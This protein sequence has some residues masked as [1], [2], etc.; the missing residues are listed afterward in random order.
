MDSFES[1]LNVIHKILKNDETYT[2]LTIGTNHSLHYHKH[3]EIYKET[4][5]KNHFAEIL[6]NTLHN[7][8][9]VNEIYITCNLSTFACGAHK[10]I[11]QMIKMRM[12][13]SI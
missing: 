7:N 12:W 11:E 5:G 10:Y 1:D 8:I 13:K 2:K 6:Y 3:M 9:Y 4:Y